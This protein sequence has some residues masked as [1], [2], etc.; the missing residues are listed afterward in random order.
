MHA[1]QIGN[2]QLSIKD[3]YCAADNENYICRDD[4]KL[5]LYINITDICNAKCPF[6]VNP[7]R[8]GG[9]NPFSVGKLKT[10]LEKVAPFIYGVSITGGE[11]MLQP[12]LVDEVAVA[13]TSI[14]GRYVELDLVTNG[15]SIENVLKLRNLRRF[16]SI[17]ISRHR[18][19]D[20]ANAA[21]FGTKVPEIGVIKEIISQLNDPAQIV[22]NCVM[23]KGGVCSA[24]DM[25]EYLEMAAWAGVRNTSF[26]GMFMAN[27][28]CR[29]NYVS[30]TDIDLSADLRFRIWN[31]FNDYGFCRCCNGDYRS[32]N[33]H[34]RFYYRYP[35][36]RKATYCRQLVYTADNRLLDGFGGTE[37]II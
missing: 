6:C 4:N 5:W 24:E 20:A 12:A 21:L 28:F 35:G 14:L 1:I 26:V 18:I 33:G 37:I 34:V 15:T 30:L 8:R 3:Y 23:Q 10:T 22:L 11:P 32:I 31:K 27:S 7:S 25:S 13:V 17:H 19:E 36:K 9:N 2:R 16:E 29:E